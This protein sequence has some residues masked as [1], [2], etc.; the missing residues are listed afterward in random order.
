MICDAANS[1]FQVHSI[2]NQCSLAVWVMILLFRFSSPFQFFNGDRSR[3]IGL[4]FFAPDDDQYN[5]AY[6][7]QTTKMGDSGTVFWTSALAWMEPISKILSRVVYV[8]PL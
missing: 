6:K 3:Y 7:R 8:M 1:E 2:S 5:P 4:R